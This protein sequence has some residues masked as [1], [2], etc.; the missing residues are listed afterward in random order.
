[1]RVSKAKE[2]GI[3]LVSPLYL[4]G[5]I[6]QNNLSIIIM[7]KTLI[8]SCIFFNENYIN[9]INLL[10]KT[11]ILF[12]NPHNN[13][14]YLIICNPHF[15]KKIIQTSIFKLNYFKPKIWTINLYTL[16]HAA[17]SRL[18]IFQYQHIKKYKK[19]LYLDNDILITNLLYYLCLRSIIN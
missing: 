14:D 1:M 2:G 16:F 10:I 5:L 15:K 12:G 11:Y 6:L 18:I 13:I 7:S 19:I 9:L 8:Y 3:P 17:A 4:P